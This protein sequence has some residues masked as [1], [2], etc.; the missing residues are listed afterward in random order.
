LNLEFLKLEKNLK[1]SRFQF[2]GIRLLKVVPIFDPMKKS[3]KRFIFSILITLFFINA[4]NQIL[5]FSKIQKAAIE[6]NEEH[7]NAENDNDF[8]EETDLFIDSFNFQHLPFNY[9]IAFLD[10]SFKKNFKPSLDNPPPQL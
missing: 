3:L 2:S 5:Q 6:L 1:K 4:V 7:E 9:Q 8:A 10:T